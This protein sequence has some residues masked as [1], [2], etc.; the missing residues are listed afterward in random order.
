MT[1]MK[2]SVTGLV[3]HK[4]NVT[5]VNSAFV[6]Q[7]SRPDETLVYDVY[8]L[9]KQRPNDTTFTHHKVIPA[10]DP[11]VKD[12]TITIPGS[13]TTVKGIYYLGLKARDTEGDASNLYVYMH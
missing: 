12:I 1:A 11:G 5:V 6:V 7:L 8:V 13:V 3:Y 4:I 9:P 2:D 10:A